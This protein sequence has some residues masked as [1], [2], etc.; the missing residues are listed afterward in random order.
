MSG[1]LEHLGLEI[2]TMPS[3]EKEEAKISCKCVPQTKR[4]PQMPSPAA[5]PARG[6]PEAE[7][8]STIAVST[9]GVIVRTPAAAT[10]A[11]SGRRTALSM[12]AII[13]RSSTMVNL[14][15]AGIIAVHS[16]HRIYFDLVAVGRSRDILWDFLQQL[17]SAAQPASERGDEIVIPAIFAVYFII[18]C[19]SRARF[20]LL[21]APGARCLVGEDSRDRRRG[22]PLPRHLLR[23]GVVA[24]HR[25]A[26]HRS[27]REPLHRQEHV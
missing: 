5:M 24:A 20:R 1:H 10:K 2:S 11:R 9:P 7:V 19:D 6:P 16:N 22:A 15:G 13:V 27:S 21:D 23:E 18:S 14:S 25:K 17:R 4:P 8:R 12:R 3:N 26:Q